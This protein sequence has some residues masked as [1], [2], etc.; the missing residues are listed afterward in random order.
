MLQIIKA[1]E[2][3]KVSEK[4]RIAR[5]EDV[6]TEVLVSVQN[7]MDAGHR[8]TYIEYLTP[9]HLAMLDAAGYKVTLSNDSKMEYHIQW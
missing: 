5:K 2:A 9:E 3:A 1:E 4:N 7:A 8:E 6:W